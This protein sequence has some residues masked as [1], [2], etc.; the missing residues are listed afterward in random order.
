M[1]LNQ[2]WAQSDK[3]LHI[4]VVNFVNHPIIPLFIQTQRR[5]PNNF[6]LVS[7]Y[8]FTSF[9]LLGPTPSFRYLFKVFKASFTFLHT[10]SC[11]HHSRIRP[12][13]GYFANHTPYCIVIRHP[14]KVL[15]VALNQPSL[16]FQR[17]VIDTFFLRSFLYSLSLP[18]YLCVILPKASCP[19]R[20]QLYLHC[21]NSSISNRLLIDIWRIRCKKN[22]VETIADC[23]VGTY[24]DAYDHF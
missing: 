20:F 15:L 4:L 19:I 10:I 21:Y 16:P 3:D 1:D 7:L 23:G 6:L 9:L 12:Y 22:V 11:F 24:C 17:D 14:A 8:I 13:C 2:S 18:F 5:Y